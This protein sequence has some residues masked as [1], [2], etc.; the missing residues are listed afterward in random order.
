[1]CVFM[2]QDG[3]EHIDDI[4]IVL[5][6]KGRSEQLNLRLNRSVHCHLIERTAAAVKHNL[7]LK[8]LPE[9]ANFQ[10]RYEF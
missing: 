7:T 5:D 4:T 2:S 10:P 6:I 1:M 9:D 8:F 3:L